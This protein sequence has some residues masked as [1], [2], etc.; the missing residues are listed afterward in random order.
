MLSLRASLIVS[1]VRSLMNRHTNDDEEK[2][3][4]D[5][6]GPSASVDV[7]VGM[8][9]NQAAAPSRTDFNKA[10]IILVITSESMKGFVKTVADSIRETSLTQQIEPAPRP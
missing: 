9:P 7:C 8:S 6:S 5:R 10:S 4:D 3:A 1:A 2:I